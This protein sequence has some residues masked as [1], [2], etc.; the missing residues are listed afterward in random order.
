[1]R[2]GKVFVDWSQNDD[3]K[4]TVCAYSLRA[5]P[6][7]TVSAPIEWQECEKALKKKDTSNLVFEARQMLKRIERKGDIFAPVTKLKQK[8]P[9]L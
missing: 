2:N 4:T 6:K 7:P 9:S 5:G 3:H 8:L 1:L